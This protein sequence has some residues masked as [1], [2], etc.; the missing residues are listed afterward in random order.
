MRL[1]E[2]ETLSNS[3]VSPSSRPSTAS[4]VVV[5]A[6]T[7]ASDGSVA[8]S[9]RPES[10]QRAVET[11]AVEARSSMGWPHGERSSTTEV[12]IPDFKGDDLVSFVCAVAGAECSLTPMELEVARMRLL[13]WQRQA[14]ATHMGRSTHTIDSHLKAVRRKLGSGS[15]TALFKA[16]VE[17]LNR[18]AQATAREL[19]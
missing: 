11:T 19:D 16:A 5:A 4:E 1:L 14:I 15:A 10:D 3:T 17:T 9:G 2:S 12:P 18:R 6:T 13:G 7:P 8:P